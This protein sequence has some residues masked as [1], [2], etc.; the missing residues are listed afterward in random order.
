M[1]MVLRATALLLVIA[2]TPGAQPTPDSTP[3][4]SPSPTPEVTPMP[5]EVTPMPPEADLPAAIMQPIYADAAAR[6]GVPVHELVVIRA[7]AVTW[8]DPSL[9]CPQP[10]MAYPQVLVDGYWVVLEA[11]GVEYDY[12]GSGVGQFSLCEIPLPERQQ[13]VP[14]N[15]G[16][17]Y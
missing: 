11:G 7:E 10:G 14:G 9:G 6:S 16:L 2:C 4:P 12:R 1:N 15:G 8:S 13:P 5:P 3:L 17:D